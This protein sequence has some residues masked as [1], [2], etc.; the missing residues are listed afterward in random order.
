MKLDSKLVAKRAW[1]IFLGEVNEEGLVLIAD[2][3]ARELA[4]RSLRVAEIYSREEAAQSQ[5]LKQAEKK[6]KTTAKQKPEAKQDEK[7]EAK[8]S[9]KVSEKPA[10]KKVAA[11]PQ[12]AKKPEEKAPEVEPPVKK[13][14]EPAPIKEQPAQE[15][16]ATDKPAA[17]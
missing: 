12:E 13:A 7:P 6:N 1:K 17:E 15:P 3:D 2:K 11:E 9:A 8:P 14:E 16:E 5:K 4:K 10:V